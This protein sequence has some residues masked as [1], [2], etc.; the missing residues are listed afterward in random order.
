MSDYVTWPWEVKVLILSLSVSGTCRVDV[1]VSM[2]SRHA[3]LSRPKLRGRRS[4]STVLSQDCLGLPTLDPD[5]V[6]RNILKTWEIEAR[7]RRTTSGTT[8]RKLHMALW[9]RLPWVDITIGYLLWH[10]LN[11]ANCVCRPTSWDYP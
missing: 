10:V 1:A 5:Y 2:S 4:S 7:C 11:F 6:N 9:N 3:D 8:N